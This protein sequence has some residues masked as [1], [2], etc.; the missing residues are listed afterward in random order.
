MIKLLDP[1]R[2]PSGKSSLKNLAKS[3]SPNNSS[4]PAPP[5]KVSLPS[6]PNKLSLSVPPSNKSSPSRPEMKSS[7][8]WPKSVSLLPS[9]SDK[10]KLLDL[11]IS[12]PANVS[13][14]LSTELSIGTNS[15]STCVPTTASEVPKTPGPTRRNKPSSLKKALRSASPKPPII[16]SLPSP[17]SM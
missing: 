12:V 17:P 11:I 5:T 16:S 2:T 1:T 15:P 13:I 4:V 6:P 8:C 3:L 7:P 10:C 9:D 14:T